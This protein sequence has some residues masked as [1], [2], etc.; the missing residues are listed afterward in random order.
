[1]LDA[2]SARLQRPQAEA[3]P[4]LRRNDAE[5]SRVLDLAVS[6]KRAPNGAAN[7]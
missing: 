5:G 2:V 7:L 4:V 1:M 3:K 6:P